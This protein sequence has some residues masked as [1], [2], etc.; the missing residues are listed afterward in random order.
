MKKMNFVLKEAPKYDMVQF[1]AKTRGYPGMDPALV[2]SALAIFSQ[3]SVLM[4]AL[5]EQFTGYKISYGRF[6]VLMMLV[7]EPEKNFSPS[8]IAEQFKVTKATVTGLVDGLEKDGL[9]RRE[10]HALDRRVWIIKI[11]AEGEEV[12]D[13]VMPQLIKWYAHLMK[14]LT[15]AER[16]TLVLLLAKVELSASDK[17][18]K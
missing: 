5:D 15:A 7:A 17:A 10:D 3:A 9:I 13:R 2:T 12:V 16:S 4:S 6:C 18:T 14:N 1:V 8:E 11:T